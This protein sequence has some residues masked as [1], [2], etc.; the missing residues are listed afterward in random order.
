M[1]SPDAV[2]MGTVEAAAWDAMAVVGQIA[3]VHGLRGQVIVNPETDFPRERF[4]AGGLLFV[5]R[6]GAVRA[7]TLTTVRFHHDRPVIGFEGI[8]DVDA[9]ATLTGAELRVPVEELPRLPAGAFYRHHLVGCQ[10][11]T[12]AG[13]TVGL[14]RAVEGGAGGHRLVVAGDSGE[15]L[16]PLAAAICTAIDIAAGRIVI[17]PPEGLLDLNTKARAG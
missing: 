4:R 8:D 1:E 3:R 9:A 12:E 15:V 13:T 2:A 11:V 5:N 7:L 17:A 10:V 6:L 14:V 16:V